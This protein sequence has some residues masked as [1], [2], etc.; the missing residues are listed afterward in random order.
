VSWRFPAVRLLPCLCTEAAS[1]FPVSGQQHPPSE[2]LLLV[3]SPFL[4]PGERRSVAARPAGDRW[5][6]NRGKRTTRL[7]ASTV[8]MLL[9]P[10]GLAGW[11]LEGSRV[12]AGSGTAPPSRCDAPGPGGT[13]PV[14]SPGT[15]WPLASH[16]SATRTGTAL[17]A[18]PC[19]HGDSLGASHLHHGSPSSASTC[20]PEGFGREKGFKFAF[21]KEK[22]R[23]DASCSLQLP[24]PPSQ[25]PPAAP[26]SPW[27]QPPSPPARSPQRRRST[28]TA[29][30]LLERQHSSAGR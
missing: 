26:A 4:T 3:P 16:T 29:E 5:K 10:E 22:R 15:P 30:G 13:V 14:A 25:L 21:S 11:V 6:E 24:A 19:L 7:P 27:E 9:H 12:P 28:F 20:L 23:G 17:P 8:E 2:Q 18:Q 1:S